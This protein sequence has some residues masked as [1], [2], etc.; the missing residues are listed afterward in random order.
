M[1]GATTLYA[2]F[3]WKEGKNIKKQKR[4]RLHY[5]DR[6]Q[7]EAL[8]KTGAGVSEIAAKVGIH[9]DTLYKELRR[10]GAETL[11]DYSADT[12]QRAI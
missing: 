6:K 12:G 3:M 10:S 1:Q 7:I 5:E 8:A 2:L 11:A 9:R 4:K